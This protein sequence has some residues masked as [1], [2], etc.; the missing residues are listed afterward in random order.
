MICVLPSIWAIQKWKQKRTTPPLA[1]VSWRGCIGLVLLMVPVSYCWSKLVGVEDWAHSDLQMGHAVWLVQGVS[2]NSPVSPVPD[3]LW[4]CLHH[5]LVSSHLK[6]WKQIEYRTEECSWTDS[7]E[8][9]APGSPKHL[10][11]FLSDLHIIIFILSAAISI[12]C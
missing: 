1:S 9:C 3:T 10:K 11:N 7:T 8:G 4:V 5:C 6:E 12:L 2:W